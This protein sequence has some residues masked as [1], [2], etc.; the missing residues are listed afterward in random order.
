MALHICD[1]GGH[2]VLGTEIAFTQHLAH[3]IGKWI[4]VI[5]SQRIPKKQVT[6][7]FWRNDHQQ[8][9]MVSENVGEKQPQE[10]LGGITQELYLIF[11][12]APAL[13]V[14]SVPKSQG[15]QPTVPFVWSVDPDNAPE[16]TFKGC[17]LDIGPITTVI[18]VYG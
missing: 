4:D 8:T 18:G 17:V 14:T 13:E 11:I 6:T 10:I 9:E 7:E 3:V 15:K 2:G 1:A 12:H 5:V 16:V